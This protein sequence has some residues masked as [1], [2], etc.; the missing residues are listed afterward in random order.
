MSLRSNVVASYI[1]QGWTAV[2]ATAFLPLYARQLGMEAYGLIGVFSILQAWIVLMDLGLSPAISREMARLMAGARGVDSTRDLLRS[3]EVLCVVAVCAVVVVT[4]LGAG[5]LA[6]VWLRPHGLP[7]DVVKLAI[8]VMGSVLAVR[9]FEQFYRGALQGLQDLVWFNGAQI[10]LATLRWAGAYIVLRR[11]PDITIFFL[12]QGGVSCVSVVTWAARTY[13][14]L[15]K[16]ERMGT[17]SISALR[18]V[19]GFASGMFVSGTLAF[20]L[21]QS[22]KIIISRL[23]PLAALGAYT[24]AA[25]A[26]GGLL[27]V[28]APMSNAVYPRLTE[29]ASRNDTAALTSTYQ[30]ACQWMAAFIVPPALVMTCF[31]AATL[32]MWTGN[33]QLATTVAPLLAVLAFGTLCNGFMSLPYFL[34]LAYGW[35]SLAVRINVFA[36]V[37]IIPALIWTVPR[38]GTLGAAWA[39]LTLNAAYVI[40]MGNMMHVRILPGSKRRWYG[41]AVGLPLAVGVGLSLCMK[42]LTPHPS[43]RILA[44]VT[45]AVVGAILF[46]A[47]LSVLPEVRSDIL[48]NAQRLRKL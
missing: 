26:A 11:L 46:M 32:L 45:V 40:V 31:P 25:S 33:L 1:G 12:W 38:F 47:M 36:V 42:C 17:F 37:L 29:L 41:N 28:M 23:L 21:T 34:Q 9:W 8:E 14:L 22:D 39:W 20:L 18:E 43:T 35:T 44:A 16:H 6:R 10:F 7:P 2:M 15:P 5:W 4:Q 30:R 24:L 48:R 3:M 13:W 19:K 27:Q